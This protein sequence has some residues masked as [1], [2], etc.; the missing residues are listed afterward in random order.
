MFD[1]LALFH[2]I[3]PMWLFALVPVL[4]I[5]VGL[6]LKNTRQN[7]WADIIDPH[8]LNHLLVGQK[9]IQQSSVSPLLFL[10]LSLLL[11]VFALAG[12]TWQKRPL[13]V[14][15]T[16]M[17]KVILLDLSL[18]MNA[19]D[20]KP[21]RLVRARHKIKDLLAKTKE[22]QV[23]LIVYAG[24]AFVISP[25][26]TDA[27]TILTMI[28]PLSPSLMPVLGSEPHTAF[29]IADELLTNAGVLSGQIIW[30]TDGISDKD[31]SLVAE[32]LKSSRHQ[33]SILAVGTKQGSPI[34]LADKQGFL[35][36][37]KGG[38][39]I[40]SL[41][42]APLEQLAN[43]GGGNITRLTTDDSDINHLLSALSNPQEFISSDDDLEMD[44]WIEL[45]PWLLL[46]VL[47]IVIMAFR[48]GV[49]VT[50]LLTLIPIYPSANVRATES[51]DE[52]AVQP[53]AIEKHWKNLW[54]TADQQ[55]AVAFQK[56]EHKS[57]AD[58]FQQQD[59][60]SA[61]MY[62]SGQYNAANDLLSNTN[63]STAHYNKGNTLAQLG[64]LEESIA[65]YE[66]ALS[67]SPDMEDAKF[68]KALVEEMLKKKQE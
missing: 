37:A 44:T 63:T 20:I 5:I 12:P 52:Q 61:A 65:A 6:M 53:S 59:W 11:S 48:K 45:G 3:R 46:P 30:I 67:A 7:Q 18:S 57:A 32:Q 26:T 17:S 41:H 31:Y 36:D 55:A 50:L 22:G 39:V 23:A 58:L 64:R 33:I 21:S 62:K 24:D 16:E 2:F 4:L 19:T 56:N 42:I 29:K 9:K 35:K 68:N 54:Q 25:L 60:K 8:L 13:P 38:I 28:P 27:N 14:F 1:S 34:P 10:A 47:L 49:V 43:I 15:E 66:S 51:S 40:P